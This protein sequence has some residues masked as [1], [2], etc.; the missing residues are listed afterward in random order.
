MAERF[1]NHRMA[2]E[3]RRGSGSHAAEQLIG[4]HHNNI[5]FRRGRYL[6]EIE[7]IAAAMEKLVH[8]AGVLDGNLVKALGQIRRAK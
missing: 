4:L 7:G 6:I 5:P 3:R 2:L 8:M 1:P